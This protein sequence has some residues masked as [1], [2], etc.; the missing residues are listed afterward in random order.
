M[1]EHDINK[2][3]HIA[4]SIVLKVMIGNEVF[5]FVGVVNKTKQV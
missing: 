3:M 5:S 1:F 4:F 2:T